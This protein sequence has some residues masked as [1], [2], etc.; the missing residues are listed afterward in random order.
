MARANLLYLHSHDTGRYIQPY[1]YAVPSPHLQRLAEE[2][3]LFRRAFCANPTCS[4][5]RAS[6]LTG[7]WPHSSGML[8]LA[9]RGFRLNDYGHHIVR[10]LKAHGYHCALSS[11]GAQHVIRRK[12]EQEIIGYDEVFD[13][14]FPG[15]KD[16][17]EET[18]RFLAAA[19][20]P[21][22]LSVGLGDVH[23]DFP[24]PACDDPLTDPR[25]VQPPEPLPDTPQTRRD[26]AAY[27]TALRT[28]DRKMG[29][30]LKALETN[31]L[32]QNTLVLCT[33]DHGVAFPRMKCNLEDS[34]IGVFLIMRGP[35]IPAGRCLDGMVSHVDV[36][37]T[38]C[39]LL[40]MER[41]DWLQGLSFRP[42]IRGQAEEVRDEVFAEVNYHAACEPMRCVRTH[43]W[44]Y[45]RRYYD[46]PG[47]VLPNCDSSP[48]KDL[49]LDQGWAERVQPREALFDLTFDPHETD[50]LAFAPEHR[51]VLRDM[52][53][54][55]DR[56]MADTDD[57]LLRGGVP[58]PEGARVTC[59]DEA[60]PGG[61]SYIVA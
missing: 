6:L 42:L 43:R 56:W 52:R 41:P 48:S 13:P 27:N 54:R 57:P 21:F 34:G 17:V 5:S 20:H 9:H 18:S 7:Q 4:P 22:F 50:N 16:P 3:T 37:P 28:Q 11:A 55:L 47:P 10:V 39:D 29:A 51:P 38:L 8:G 49:W 36:F 32:A 12:D 2:G 35:G 60:E 31:G 1:G 23:R 26:M 58:A 59:Q 24:E 15:E 33:T 46:R 45:I 19:P 44:K 25:Y 14:V 61:K 40:D 30:V 53:E